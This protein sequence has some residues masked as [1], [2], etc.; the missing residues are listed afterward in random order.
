MMMPPLPTLKW[1]GVFGAP[2][3]EWDGEMLGPTLK[4]A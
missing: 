3:G 1:A 2:G 4:P